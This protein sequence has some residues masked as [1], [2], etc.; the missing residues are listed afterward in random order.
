MAATPKRA[1]PLKPIGFFLLLAGWILVL[2]ALILLKQPGAR[3]IFVL[4]GLAVEML[5]LILVVRSH[6][7]PTPERS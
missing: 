3:S 6:I 5:G 4:A 2:S 7:S 1:D